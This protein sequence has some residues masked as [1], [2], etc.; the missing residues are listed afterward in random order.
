MK[1]VIYT[2]DSCSYCV[3]AKT[4]ISIKNLEYTEYKLGVD[5]TRDDFISS[6][7]EQ[8]TLP[9]IFVDDEKIGGFDE[10]R[11]YLANKAA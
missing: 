1:I 3:K 11:I 10:F 9:L 5:I 6:F 4:L 2:K 7:P 8:K